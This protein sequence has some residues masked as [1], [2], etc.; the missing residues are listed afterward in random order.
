[1]R[2]VRLYTILYGGK[3]NMD[4][5]TEKKI[6]GERLYDGKVLALEKDTVRLPDGNTAIRE[7]IRKSAAVCVVPLTDDNNVIMVDQFRYPYAEVLTEIPAGKLEKGEDAL[8]GAIR[9]LEEE[10]GYTAGK[11]KF[12]GNYYPTPAIID[13][14]ISMYVATDL[15]KGKVHLDEDEF[16]TSYEIPLDELCERILNNEIPDGKTQVAILKTAALIKKGEI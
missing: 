11:M 4:D 14:F 8:D 6:S 1:M 7:I 9:E 13:E 2:G 12:I 10:T 5:L 16:L 15:Q 3:N